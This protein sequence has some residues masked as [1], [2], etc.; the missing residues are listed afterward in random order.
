MIDFRI[1]GMSIN[2]SFVH[3]NLIAKDWKKLADFYINVFGCKPV[4]PERH[5]SGK[6]LDDATGLRN[7]RIEGIHLT[8]PGIS[9]SSVTLEIFQYMENHKEFPKTINNPG[10]AHIAFKVEN[11]HKALQA[12]RKY[13]GGSIGKVVT[14]RINGVGTITFVYAYDPEGN[15]IELQKWIYDK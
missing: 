2:S 12:V 9:N 4:L 3:V 7:V 11:V 15:I 8:F 1:N 6:W 10:F 14:E 5:L 13:G